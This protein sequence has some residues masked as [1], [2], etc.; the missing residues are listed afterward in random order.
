MEGSQVAA[1]S[2]FVVSY[3]AIVSG[4]VHRTI[5]AISGA[6]VMALVVLRGRDLTSMVNWD[7]LLFI[8]GMMVVI[9]SMER[10]GVFRWLGLH[11]VRAAQLDPLRLFLI[12]PALSAILSA[13]VDSITVMLF[14]ATLTVEICRVARLRPLPLIIAEITAANVGGA[15][16][17]VGDPPN[18]ILGTHFGL[19]FWDFVLGT[20]VI[21]VVAVA[22]NVACFAWLFRRD[23]RAARD[24]FDAHPHER[25]RALSLMDP[26]DAIGDRVLFAIGWVALLLVVALL[27]T[28]RITG[29]PVGVVGAGAAAFVLL[30]GGPTK[31]TPSILESVDWMTLVFFAGLFLLVGGLEST[32]ALEAL[33]D[34]ILSTGG[35]LA[36]IL[37]IL[38]WVGAIG[39]AVVDNVPFAATMAPVI[40][41]LAAS[42]LP[43][44]PL[45]WAAALGTDVGGNATPIGASAN[46]VGLAIYER[47]TGERVRWGEY[48]RVALPTTILVLVVINGLLLLLH[49]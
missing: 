47:T 37:T 36:F 26:R 34:A 30:V 8:F 20:G 38:L 23:I 33:A 41:H 24:H 11:A 3:G 29:I 27:V 45:V 5:A 31:R 7:T 2:V 1:L 12:L 25:A 39:S 22:V 32:G 49:A 14:L 21:A 48:L 15:A 19:S 40:G 46:V 43:L 9:G 35:G 13:F 4:K 10:A 6:L 42:G 16:T 28:H 17:M 18:V 44:Q